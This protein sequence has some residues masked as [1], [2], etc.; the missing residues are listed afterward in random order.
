[1]TTHGSAKEDR[2]FSVLRL[3]VVATVLAFALAGFLAG[4]HTSSSGAA[5]YGVVVFLLILA[6]GGLLRAGVPVFA[7][8]S[9]R[10]VR[11]RRQAHVAT[12]VLGVAWGGL[13][14]AALV[15]LG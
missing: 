11:Q 7:A 2:P 14:L 15:G 13:A 5:V 12:W 6:T 8:N 9:A 1:M 3:V 4:R 10:T